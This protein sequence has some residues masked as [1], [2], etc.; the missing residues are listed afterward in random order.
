MGVLDILQE[1]GGCAGGKA[2]YATTNALLEARHP[3]RQ[4]RKLAPKTIARL[5]PLFPEFDLSN[6]RFITSASLP[7][8]WFPALAEAQAMTF[9]SHIWFKAKRKQVEDTDEGLRLLMHEL[10]HVRQY[11]ERGSSKDVFACH[12]GAGFLQGGSYETNPMEIEAFQFVTDH[13]LPPV[14]AQHW[15][16]SA[17]GVGEWTR[18]NT[19][20][21]AVDGMGFGDFNGDGRTDV[22]RTTGT[23]WLVSWGGS[24][25]W[26]K[27]KTSQLKLPDL[28]F[29]DFNGDGRTDVL[30]TTGTE[31]L[32]SWGG[33][34]PWQKLN[35]SKVELPDLGFGDFNG[36]RRTDVL[37]TTGIEWLV[38][39]GGSSPWQKLNASKV[40]LPDLG[41]GDFNGDGRTDV[42]R[43]TGTEWLVSWGG[44]SPWEKLKTSQLKLGDLGFG[45]FNGDGRTDVLRTTGTEWLVSWGGSSPWQKLKTSQLK[46]GE[47]GF[48]DFNGD[49]HTDLLGAWTAGR[50]LAVC[51]GSPPPVRSILGQRLRSRLT[52]RQPCEALRRWVRSRGAAS[53]SG[54]AASPWP[55]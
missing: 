1:L 12:Y 46:L 50:C 6:V 27:L 15:F 36:D 23:E 21:L 44:S 54:R 42:L 38:S 39:W 52:S 13:P 9:G 45:D 30:R 34:S 14:A 48:G 4:R 16:V 5:Q 53:A 49:T 2:I 3:R 37:R 11:R 18:L 43:T 19:S 40:E 25:P 26:D 51:P 7:R 20:G 31:W 22:L 29:G 17:S 47:L 28:G 10:V 33:S 8:N 24:G 32:V 55:P 41:F 35:A